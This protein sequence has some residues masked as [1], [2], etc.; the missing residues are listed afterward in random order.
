MHCA[1]IRSILV[2]SETKQTNKETN[3]MN[4]NIF[5]L[6]YSEC[7]AVAAVVDLRDT[8][9]RLNDQ[10]EWLTTMGGINDLAELHSIMQGGCASGAFMSAVTYYRASEVMAE[11]GNDVLDFV[12]DSLG[13]LP[14][15][16][17]GESW[18]GMAVFYLSCA[19]ELWCGQFSEIYY[20]ELEL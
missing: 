2:A 5:E 10:P 6:S 3:I 12:E 18:S 1:L 11:H 14:T 15:P 13:E 20:S 16:P 8:V 17:K 4:D 9:E 19:V 7:K